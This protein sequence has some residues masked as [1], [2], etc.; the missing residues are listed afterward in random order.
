MSVPKSCN[1]KSLNA[2]RSSRPSRAPLL[3][4]IPRDISLR[5]RTDQALQ[6]AKEAAEAAT[7]AKS[8]FLANK[9]HEIRTP[10]NGVVGMLELA[11]E[12]RLTPEQSELLGMAKDSADT[13]LALV[14]D[15]LDFS[16]VEAGKLELECAEFDPAEAV[17]EALHTM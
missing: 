17:G 9:S 1:K 3:S 13:L 2:K 5:K 11:R 6:Q 4:L 8:E 10:L 15:I 14:N 7:R 12:T 16:K